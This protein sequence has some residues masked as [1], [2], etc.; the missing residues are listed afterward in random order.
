MAIMLVSG[1]S[2]TYVGRNAISGKWVDLKCGQNM[3]MG[4]GGSGTCVGTLAR[5]FVSN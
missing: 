4:A 5:V 1:V 3:K 2:G